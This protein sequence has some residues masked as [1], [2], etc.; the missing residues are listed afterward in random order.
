MGHG[1][2]D[3]SRVVLAVLNGMLRAIFYAQIDHNT[4]Y[5]RS[6]SI[7]AALARLPAAQYINIT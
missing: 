7:D 4:P 5:Y 6:R 2:M 3:S 1:P